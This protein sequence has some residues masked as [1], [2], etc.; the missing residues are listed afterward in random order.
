[1]YAC[2]PVFVLEYGNWKQLPIQ[3]NGYLIKSA[4]QCIINFY[5]EILSKLGSIA[6]QFPCPINCLKSK[7]TM[8]NHIKPKLVLTN[9]FYQS[10]FSNK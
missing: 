8:L 4:D 7:A 5:S 1:M 3:E 10:I 2:S 6:R 9:S